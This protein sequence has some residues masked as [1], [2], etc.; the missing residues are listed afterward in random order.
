MGPPAKIIDDDTVR[1]LAKLGYNQLETHAIQT[2][3]ARF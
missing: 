3:D 2:S 1:K